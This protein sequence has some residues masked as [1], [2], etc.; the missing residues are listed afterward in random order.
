MTAADLASSDDVPAATRF[1]RRLSRLRKRLKQAG[2]VD[3]LLVSNPVDVRYLTG[4]IGEDSWLAVPLRGSRRPIL[5]SDARFTE[6]IRLEMRR[7]LGEQAAELVLREGRMSLAV[8]ERLRKLKSV[9][10]IGLQSAHATLAHRAALKKA[11]RA[12][13]ASIKV[14]GIDDGLIAQRAVKDHAELANIRAAAAIQTQA[15]QELR[16]WVEPGKSERE[17]AAWLDHR[18][19]DL[20]A[21]GSS[22]KTIVATGVNAALP[23]AIPGDTKLRVTQPVL[24]DWGAIAGGYCSDMTRLFSFRPIKGRMREVYSAVLAAQAAGI[25]AVQ[26]G[27]RLR[28]VDAAARTVLVDAGLGDAFGHG[29][30]HG[31]GLDIHEEPRLARKAPKL[32]RLEPGMVVT[33]E[34]GA[35]LPGIGGVRIEDDVV[36]TDSGHEVLT[37]LPKSLDDLPV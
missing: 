28:D 6:Q 31:I 13:G 36:V 4:F 21:D 7:G 23:H 17:V 25:E 22:F 1:Q 9:E 2:R 19:R 5:F 33:V 29:L 35:Y 10:R 12:V 15:F 3:L 18:M 34:P 27:A 30:G 20:G 32:G 8:A 14:R 11:F 37:H 24:V 26:P 16:D